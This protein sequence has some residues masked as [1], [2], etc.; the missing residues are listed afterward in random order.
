M[1][2]KSGLRYG[3]EAGGVKDRGFARGEVV[4]L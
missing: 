2:G 1:E 3:V 4:V